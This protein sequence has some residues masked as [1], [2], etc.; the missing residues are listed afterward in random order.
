M[1][2]SYTEPLI[3]VFAAVALWGLFRLRS[4]RRFR[5][6]LAAVSIWLLISW[7]PADW[8]LSRHLE[9]RYPVRPF[10]T[11]KSPQAIV[12]LAT[13]ADPPNFARP[14]PVLSADFST[15]CQFAAWLHRNWRPLP[16]L[17][18]G[19]AEGNQEPMAL[20][21][22][23]QLL[24]GGVPADA[25]WTEERSRSTHEDAAFGAGI[26]RQHHVRSIVLVVDSQSMLRAEACFRK[27]G[28]EVIPAPSTFRELGPA[29]R[30]LMPNW[31]AIK[32][33]EATLHETL[34]FVWYWM[35]GWI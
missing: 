13:T 12:V 6:P 3:L 14:V 23:D 30:E 10:R 4:D 26:L 2:V 34:G 11:E 7:P 27:E 16:V 20:I 24:Q 8:L 28:I 22:R 35:R 32:R 19:G 17:A 5:L 18:C 33:N 9:A 1:R 25:I 29:S 31:Q 21:M 15:R